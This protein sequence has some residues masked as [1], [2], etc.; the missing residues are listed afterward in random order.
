MRDLHTKNEY[1]FLDVMKFLLA[2]L[3][4]TAHFIAENAVGKI[5]RIVD[6]ASSLY[7]IA[8]PFFFVCSGF[9]LFRKMGEKNDEAVVISY[10][11]KIVIMY[12]GW[13]VVYVAFEMATWIR[14]GAS[15]KEVFHYILTAIT[16][17]TYKTIWF[18]PATV[19]GVLMVY[20]LN[21]KYGFK[22]T[23]IISIIFYVIGCIGASYS[24]I[25][26]EDTLPYQI[27]SVYNYIFTSSRNGI[28]NAFPF[29]TIGFLV[30]K[31][32]QTGMR[33]KKLRNFGLLIVLGAAFVAEA[34][35]IKF[36]FHADNANTLLFLLPFSYYFMMWC[37]GIQMYSSNITVWLRRISINIFLCQRLY[38]SA[39]PSLFP[40]SV[41]GSMI[42]G[43]PYAGLLFVVLLTFL[44][45][46]ALAILSNRNKWLRQFF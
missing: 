22:K 39:F 29:V 11:K 8:V 15:L 6:Y 7:V 20:K 5:N 27:L 16:Y 36:K 3:I 40:K 1:G 33:E 37:L 9:L 21:K 31:K 30:A 23:F 13:S 45:A 34:F 42:T 25:F 18:L 38:L 17:S 4:V 12:A 10:C 26:Q 41:L 2:L 35:I 19:I 24:F 44:T 46:V 14:F 43:N 28:F 32:E